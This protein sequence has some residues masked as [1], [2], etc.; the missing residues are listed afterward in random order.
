MRRIIIINRAIAYKFGKVPD[1]AEKI[2]KAEDW[3]STSNKF[4][5]AVAVL[6]DDFKRAALLMKKIGKDGEIGI[7][8]YQEWP[9][10][11]EFRKSDDFLVTYQDVFGQEFSIEENEP[12]SEKNESSNM[13]QKSDEEESCK[14]IEDNSTQDDSNSDEQ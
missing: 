12:T 3:S 8:E 1:K 6:R 14:E 7:F 4:R 5:L 13:N 11:K 10:F 9:V 2:L